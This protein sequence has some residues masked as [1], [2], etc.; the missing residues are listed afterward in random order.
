[1]R[2]KPRQI[3]IKSR[4]GFLASS[5]LAE[6]GCTSSGVAS[7]TLPFIFLPPVCRLPPALLLSF[8]C[9]GLVSRVRAREAPNQTTTR[10][11]RKRER[12]RAKAKRTNANHPSDH[13]REGEHPKKFATRLSTRL[14]VAV[15]CQAHE[16]VLPRT[17]L[18]S[19]T[20]GGKRLDDQVEGRCWP[21]FLRLA[22]AERAGAKHDG[23]RRCH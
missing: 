2:K 9:C 21:R 14:R 6:L 8:V 13:R 20:S 19:A 16:R 5:P 17:Q 23:V 15:T 12:E 10:E 22:A 4:I 3:T 1:M 18:S 11:E 7:P